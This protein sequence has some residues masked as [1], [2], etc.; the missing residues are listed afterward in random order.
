VVT[1]VAFAAWML[2]VRET[3]E[4]GDS[5]PMARL[6]A[7]DQDAITA[8][9]IRSGTATARFERIGGEWRFDD[10]Q[11][12]VVNLD[13]WGGIVL[14]LSGPLAD[15]ELGQVDDLGKFGLDSPGTIELELVGGRTIR[16]SLGD[17][18]PDERHYYATLDDHRSVFLVNADWG[19]VLLTLASNPPFP[20]W[21]YQVDPAQV[22]VFE[23]D[24]GGGRSTLFL[25]T[26]P[27]QPAG[28]R[29]LVEGVPRDMRQEEVDL[30]LSLVGGPE[31]MQVLPP[32]STAD[33]ALGFATPTVT[34][35][36]TYAL[37]QPIDERVDFSTVY[38]VGGT[39]AEGGGY[40]AA[41]SDTTALLVFDGGWVDAILELSES[42]R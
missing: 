32:R 40:Y 10:R 34:L 17:R 31:A 14:L 38:V 3:D 8:V 13:R 27:D 16:V 9:A 30:A 28:G 20:Y 7:A 36:L 21:Y 4:A 29:V 23:I 22:R 35:R 6:Y 18:T 1:I 25:G 19:E 37:V 15:R 24:G 42:L 5:P 39:T 12:L 33:P 41:T 11:G 2:W 26:N